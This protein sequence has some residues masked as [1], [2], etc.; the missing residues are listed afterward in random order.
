MFKIRFDKFKFIDWFLTIFVCIVWPVL[1]MY[2]LYWGLV[3]VNI[4]DPIYRFIMCIAT[5][6]NAVLIPLD[7]MN[8]L[9]SEGLR[10]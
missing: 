8:I 10:E 1:Y 3:V 5:I 7:W 6:G 9:K 2:M 4:S